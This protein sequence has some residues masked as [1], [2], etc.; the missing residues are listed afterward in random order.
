[1]KKK[2]SRI[3]Y[4]DALRFIFML[5]IMYL[6]F[7]FI[8]TGTEV[9]HLRSSYIF[10]EAFFII[11]GFFTAHHFS[12]DRTR[13]LDNKA[14]NALFYTLKKFSG[15]FPY[16][17][18]AV[19]FG[20]LVKLCITDLN[21]TETVKEF[22]KVPV[23]L[24]FGTSFFYTGFSGPIWFLSA[25]FIVFPIFCLLIQIKKYKYLRRLLF[26][27]LIIIYI[28]AGNLETGSFP[29]LYRAFSD[30]V[31][32]FLIY[33]FSNWFS[34]IKFNKFGKIFLQAIESF[35]FAAFLTLLYPSNDIIRAH[36]EVQVF[37]FILLFIIFALIFS[38]QTYTSSIKCSFFGKIGMIV[39]PMFMIHEQI[40]RIV[41]HIH[42]DLPKIVLLIIYTASTIILSFLMTIIIPVI[43]K[44]VNLKKLLLD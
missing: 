43:L 14:K 42:L 24:V 10:V 20:F 5:F 12:K 27:F 40:A 23:D 38:R 30:L 19:I 25:M 16:M 8:Y 26:I 22:L 13:N 34:K 4:I 37:V 33:E 7:M 41:V 15:F 3:D 36:R 18:V 9:F 2:S 28:L 21:F 31:I 29:A 17:F 32:G 1:M 44:K 35:S 6:H 39:M 11:T